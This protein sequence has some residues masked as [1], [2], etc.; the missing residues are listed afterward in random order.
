MTATSERFD[1]EA[2]RRRL[3]AMTAGELRQ[4]YREISGDE[5]RSR[6]RKYLMRRILWMLQASVYGGLSSRAVALADGFEF[7]GERYGSLSAIAKAVEPG[8][9]GLV[10]PAA[11]LPG[12]FD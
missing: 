1:V 6:N 2:E 8:M 4:R 3:G 12:E 5:A 11:T 9:P 10:V 7:K